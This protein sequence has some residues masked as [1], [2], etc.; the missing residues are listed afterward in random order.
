MSRSKKFVLRYA[1]TQSTVEEVVVEAESAVEAQRIVEEHEF[2]TSDSRQVE[3][4]EFSVSD[5][6]LR[7]SAP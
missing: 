1:L 7:G 5:V 6:E 4:F 3:C 2:D